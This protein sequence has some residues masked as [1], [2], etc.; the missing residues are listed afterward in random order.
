[1]RVHV[2][3][4]ISIIYPPFRHIHNKNDYDNLNNLRC[5]DWSGHDFCRCL[6][7]CTLFCSLFLPLRHINF[8]IFMSNS[9]SKLYV[10]VKFDW[11]TVFHLFIWQ[12][13]LYTIYKLSEVCCETLLFDMFPNIFVFL[14]TNTN[15]YILLSKYAF[16]ITKRFIMYRQM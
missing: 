12:Y 16:W 4:Y 8:G 5:K 7:S 11:G 6:C 1:M 13:Y 2:Y 14:T 9:Y 3:R 15:I 10:D